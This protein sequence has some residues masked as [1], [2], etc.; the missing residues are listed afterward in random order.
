MNN[1]KWIKLAN[2]LL[3]QDLFVSVQ[4]NLWKLVANSFY[5][6]LQANLSNARD[7]CLSGFSVEAFR[8]TLKLLF[9]RSFVWLTETARTLF[10]INKVTLHSEQKKNRINFIGKLRSIHHGKKY[11]RNIVVWQASNQ[12]LSMLLFWTN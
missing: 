4:W 7:N 9:L 12:K 11:V 2:I 5:R 1:N 3:R 10:N 8:T 6:I